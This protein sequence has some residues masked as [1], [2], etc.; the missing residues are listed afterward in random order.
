MSADKIRWAVIG[1]GDICRKRVAPAVKAEEHSLLE[2]VARRDEKKARQF[3]VE[4]GS[5]K[6]YTSWE[7][8]AKDPDVDAV[9]VATPVNLHKDQ[10]IASIQAGKHVLCEKPMAMNAAECRDMV[11]A[12]RDKGVKLGVAYY[13]RFYPKVEK[14]KELL[15]AKAIGD[16]VLVRIDLH[17]RYDPAPD[18]PKA[19]RIA[20]EAGGGGALMDVGSHRLD[21]L[22]G[23]FGLPVRVA[24]RS[25]CLAHDWEVEDSATILMELENG[26]SAVANIL[27]STRS[28]AD[29]FEITGTE[30][31]ISLSPLQAPVLKVTRNGKTEEYDLPVHENVHFP[32]IEDFV[33]AVKEDREPRVTGEEG[34]KTTKIIDAAYLSQEN[35]TWVELAAV[36]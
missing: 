14:A 25:K 10:T 35:N 34:M 9:Y 3:A 13:R 18:D 24:A 19:W 11:S 1:C 16:V 12:A 17:S 20:K 31:T 6:Y 21:L 22:V 36:E 26:A 30:G 7:Q 5:N 23:F 2:A 8:A 15:D 27:W 33:D 29:D 28:G 32:L 4:F